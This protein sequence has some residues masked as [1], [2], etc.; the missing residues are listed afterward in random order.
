MKYNPQQRQITMGD[1]ADLASTFDP[2]LTLLFSTGEV[3]EDGD[4]DHKIYGFY[5]PGNTPW[6]PATSNPDDVVIIHDMCLDSE[7]ERIGC[8]AFIVHGSPVIMELHEKMKS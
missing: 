5:L 1:L 7:Y 4:G 6:C 8:D 2:N 3:N